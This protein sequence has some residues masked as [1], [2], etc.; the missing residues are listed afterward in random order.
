[1]TLSSRHMLQLKGH[2]CTNN[3]AFNITHLSKLYNNTLSILFLQ[4]IRVQQPFSFVN[5]CCLVKRGLGD[6]CKCEFLR[7]VLDVESLNVPH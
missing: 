4:P 3:L 7:M 6:F 2:D 5:L 1:M